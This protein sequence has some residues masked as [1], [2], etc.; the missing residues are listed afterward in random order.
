MIENDIVF[1][2]TTLYTKWLTY[3]SEIIRNLFPN[4][5]HIIV[6]GRNNWPYSWFY[7]I[8]KVKLSD[9]KY[10]I[11]IDEDFFITSKDELI[12]CLNKMDS[13]NID[14]MG[15][16]DG[17]HHYRGANPVAINTFLMI[18]RVDKIKNI[19][20]TDIKFGWSENGWVNSLNLKFKES[21]KAEFNYKFTKNADGNFKFEQEPYYAFL[22]NMKE[23][24]CRFEYLYPHFDDRFK[25][26]NPRFDEE[27]I[28]IGI[29]MWYTRQFDSD[30]DVW[31]MKNRE[32]YNLLEKYILENGYCSSKV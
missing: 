9:K 30:M 15:V 13:D 6:D 26:T 12:K 11:H 17:Y 8:D 18:G 10:F 24:G 25:S 29:H 32:R 19:N 1:V 3:Q 20:L 31:G 21:Y 27:S 2:T 23:L 7:W 14:L 5:E 16:P 28:D 4:S 22:W